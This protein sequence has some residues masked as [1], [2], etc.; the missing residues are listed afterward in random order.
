MLETDIKNDVGRWHRCVELRVFE[1]GDPHQPY[2]H[3]GIKTN[4]WDRRAQRLCAI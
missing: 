3:M 1:N 4:E 2:N